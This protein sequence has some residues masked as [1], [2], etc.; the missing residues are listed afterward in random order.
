MPS[1]DLTRV[2]DAIDFEKDNGE[3]E[4]SEKIR[5]YTINLFIACHPSRILR[6][7]DES[8]AKLNQ[9]ISFFNVYLQLL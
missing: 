2:I 5:K 7:Q 6:V 9:I 4:I 3:G 8:F 1:Y